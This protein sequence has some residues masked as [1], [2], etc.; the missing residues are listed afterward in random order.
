MPEELTLLPCPACDSP[1]KLTGGDE[2]YN[3]H[4]FWITCEN[5]ECGCCRVGDTVREE[6]IERWNTL[7][8][9]LTFTNEPPKVPGYYW[10]R[11]KSIGKTAWS[12]THIIPILGALN[13]YSVPKEWTDVEWAGPIPD[14]RDKADLPRAKEL[15][16][17]VDDELAVIFGGVQ[18]QG[19]LL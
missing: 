15:E 6:C 18:T 16:K 3:L 2:W 14:T 17:K 7:P 4:D 19:S 10:L 8:R 1:V 5:N 12:P 11:Y 9:A 13:N